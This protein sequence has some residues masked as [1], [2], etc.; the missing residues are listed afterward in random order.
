MMDQ[1]SFY[2]HRSAFIEKKDFTRFYSYPMDME[3]ML[4]SYYSTRN[5]DFC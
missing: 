3:I 2:L 4:M 1:I 5:E